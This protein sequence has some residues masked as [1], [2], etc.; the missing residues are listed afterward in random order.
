MEVFTCLL[1]NS[2]AKGLFPYHPMCKGIKLT[3]LC[4]ADDLL[5]FS[6][7]SNNGIQEM[8]QVLEQFKKVSGLKSNPSKCEVFF[9]GLD[10]EEKKIRAARYGY[11]LGEFPVRYLGVPLI[12]GKLSLSSCQSLIDKIVAKVKSWQAKSLSY[13]GRIELVGKVLYSLT[14]FWMSV[15]LLPKSV[16][17]E[18]ERICSNYIWGVGVGTKLR[19][20]VLWQKITYLKKEGGLG[21]RD[22]WSWNQACMVRHLWLILLQEGSLWVAWIHNY[23]LKGRDLWSYSCTSGS[24]NWR[25]VL[26][27]RGKI[28]SFIS[29]SGG[30]LRFKNAPMPTYSIKR[31]WQTL[32][33]V[34]Q[35]VNWWK[36][37]WKGKA[38]PRNRVITWLVIR[39]NINTKE[40]MKRWGYSGGMECCL[41]GTGVEDRDHLYACCPFSR[42]VLES[43]FVK[44]MQIPVMQSWD[45]VVAL[46]MSKLG[47]ITEATETGKLIWQAWVSYI[48]RERCRRLY[49]AEEKSCNV[50]VKEIKSEVECLLGS[51]RVS[52]FWDSLSIVV[53]LGSCSVVYYN[54]F[55]F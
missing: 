55:C 23:K 10:K 52:L 1:D 4:F 33:H 48:W 51:H 34:Q 38:I 6:D 53:C 8:Q 49:S 16:I 43:V 31:V 5:V 50:L 3:H 27:L 19:A 44:F 9:G 47:G 30:E 24:W 54:Q 28:A 7:G 26:K 13:A 46:I 40:R 35:T 22:M 39:G 45:E 18:V 25:K 20:N 41:C 32:R 37:V 29:S 15:F 12:S 36:L 42:R 21:F 14:Q 11:K 17:K 2:A